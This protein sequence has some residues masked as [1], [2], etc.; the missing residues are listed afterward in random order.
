M[1]KDHGYHHGRDLPFQGD[2]DLHTP[3]SNGSTFKCQV[4]LQKSIAKIRVIISIRIARAYDAY[5]NFKRVVE[6]G[7]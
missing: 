5:F 4:Y 7:Q 6:S 2:R 3:F 1:K